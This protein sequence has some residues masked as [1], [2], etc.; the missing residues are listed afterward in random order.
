MRYRPSSPTIPSTGFTIDSIW[1][2][3]ARDNG[4]DERGDNQSEIV[5]NETWCF[6]RTDR[7]REIF[8]DRRTIN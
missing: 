7:Q 6:G 2:S 1:I 4:K 5:D 3:L 8:D